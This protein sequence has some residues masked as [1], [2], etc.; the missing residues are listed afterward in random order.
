MHHGPATGG[1]ERPP[2]R[3]CP[4]CGGALRPSHREYSGAGTSVTVL[5]CSSCGCVVTGSARAD[6]DRTA[7]DARGGRSRRHRPVDEG[8]PTNPVL[9]P[10]LARRILDDISG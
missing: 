1:A 4:D 3:P 5:R 7:A 6:P 2:P 8:P 9:G 10:E